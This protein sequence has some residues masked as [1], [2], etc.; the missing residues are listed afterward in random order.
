VLTEVADVEAGAPRCARATRRPSRASAARRPAARALLSWARL[1]G[2]ESTCWTLVERAAA[3]DG[4]A[5]E[6]FGRRYLPV[7]RAYLHARWSGRLAADELEDAVQEVF[8]AF[9]R[10]DGVFAKLRPG[11]DDPFRPLLYGVVR[12]VARRVEH[13]RARK[14]DQPASASFPAED[15]AADEPSL[16]RAFDRAWAEAVVREAADLQESVARAQG[17]SALR[18]FELLRL[19]FHEDLSVAQVAARWD[20]AAD[21]L[22]KEAARAKRE[23][24]EALRS[25]VTFH[26]PA[27]RERVERE[28]RELLALLG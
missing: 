3:G 1:Q 6:E 12:N 20:V 25:V 9:L 22:H 24:K 27:G 14:R 16:A 18:R 2:P 19:L 4:G 17:G 26:L 21:A 5:R 15:A 7:V 8:V 28:C 23:F 11:R 13:E 10:D